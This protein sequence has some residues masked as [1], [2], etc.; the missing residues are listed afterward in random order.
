MTPDLEAAISEGMLQALQVGHDI[1]A[2]GG[3]ALDAVEHTVIELEN[4]PNFNAGRGAVFTHDGHHEFDAA[5][6][7]GDSLEAGSI[8][9]VQG[10]KNP[11]VLAR[12]VMDRSRYV[13]MVGK[14]AEEFAREE[15]LEMES[16][17]YFYTDLR[18]Q[19]WQQ[20][21][22]SHHTILDHSDKGEKNFSTV[23][24]VAVDTS[25][26][27]AAATSTGGM[28][29]KHYGRVGDSP[30]I[31]CGTYAD[32]ST[33]A[34]SATGHGEFFMR[35]V[36]AHEVASLMRYRGYSLQK[37]AEKVILETLKDKGGNGGLIAVDA[38]GNISMPFNTPGMY[39]ACRRGDEAPFV[40]M[41]GE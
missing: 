6:M 31:G 2:A 36:V 39:R 13:M 1:L 28:T 30:I 20:V 15:Q 35:Y 25:G 41:F 19:Q 34:I 38:Q 11:I 18:Y 29:N 4:N 40:G 8:A 24:A 26:H 33:C 27:L 23:G 22:D 7:R 37:A 9:S 17:D 32:D 3:S 10:V 16:A 21:K 5:I 14:G 12:R